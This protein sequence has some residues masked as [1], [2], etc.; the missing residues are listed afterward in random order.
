M[1]DRRAYLLM[2]VSVAA[3]WLLAVRLAGLP[4]LTLPPPSLVGQVLWDERATF[5]ESALSTLS[6]ALMGYAAANL[7]ALALAIGALYLTWLEAFTTP[8]V[9]VLKNIPFVSLASLLII[10]MGST[11]LPRLIIVVL[12]CF[13]P[14]LAN[15][16]QGLK[17]AD[18]VLVDRLRTLHGSRWEIFRYVLWPSALPYYLAAHE[19]AF[20]TSIVGAIVAEWFLSRQGLGYV[21]VKAMTEY[22]G[23]RI[24]AATLIS[25]AMSFAAYWLC[26]WLGRRLT[27]WQR[28]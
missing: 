28:A 11:L 25:S 1:T 3:V 20:T 5:A 18:R 2:F 7:I 27:R 8:W 24:Y 15:L 19:I 13:H 9:V 10:T 26:R 23:D 4:P 16:N 22:R 6:T 17:A 14:L 21:L 12:V